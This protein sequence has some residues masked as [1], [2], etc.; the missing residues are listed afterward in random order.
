MTT[1][2]VA[3]DRFSLP[4]LGNGGRGGTGAQVS[5]FL[6]VHLEEF[7][8]KL[9]VSPAKGPSQANTGFEMGH[10]KEQGGY[11]LFYVTGSPCTSM[12]LTS[13]PAASGRGNRSV[14]FAQPQ[15][16]AVVEL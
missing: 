11:A 1:K 16:I 2:A 10:P 5:D 13:M 9:H 15:K 3:P 14:Q 12:S 7:P 8:F 4:C 6:C